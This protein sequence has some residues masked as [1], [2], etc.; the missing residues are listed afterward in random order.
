[1]TTTREIIEKLQEFESL[2]GIGYVTEIV[3]NHNME[4][5][6][7]CTI[8]VVDDDLNDYDISISRFHNIWNSSRTLQKDKNNI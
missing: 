2:H 6:K 5:D 1:M 4:S 3:T 8:E 7:D